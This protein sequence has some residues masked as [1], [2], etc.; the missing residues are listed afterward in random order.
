MTP[1]EQQLHDELI[2]FGYAVSH[3]LRAPLRAIAGFGQALTEDYR[4]K[5]DEDGAK[6]LDQICNAAARMNSMIDGL[7][8]LSRVS[9]ADMRR[10]RVD[11][12]SI[13]ES[14]ATELQ[15]ADPSR[16]VQFSIAPGLA[17]NGDPALLGIAF[18]HLLSNAWKFTSRHPTARIELGREERRGRSVILV[19][20]DGAGFDQ[21]Y[22]DKL[23]TPLQRLHSASEF[24]GIG[25]GLA[26]VQRIV[27]RHGGTIEAE[28][29][30]ERGATLYIDIA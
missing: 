15:A 10:E 28:G 30:V 17:V 9:R 21:T 6:Y 3:D 24:D 11:I 20:D 27:R 4:Q 18:R 16:N 19:R 13:A 8:E 7:L 12:T 22:A 2:A 5:L 1:L 25:A 29:A 14:V 26:V 23:F